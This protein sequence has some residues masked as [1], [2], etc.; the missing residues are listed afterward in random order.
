LALFWLPINRIGLC[1][2]NSQILAKLPGLT[3]F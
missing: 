3:R 1:M 2:A